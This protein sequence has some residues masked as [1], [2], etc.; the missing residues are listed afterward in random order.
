MD[1]SKFRTRQEFIYDSNVPHRQQFII[2]LDIGYSATKVFYEKGHFV[3]PSAVKKLGRAE[4]PSIP[5]AKD[6]FYRDPSTDEVYI[7][8]YSA[9]EM[10]ES[11]E[12]N[13]TE[14]ELYSRNRYKQFDFRALAG[15]AIAIA[16]QGI[17]A[18]SREV[19]I[20]TGLPSA[21]LQGD[22]NKLID[23]LSSSFSFDYRIGK[24]T[25]WTRCD[26]QI[27]QKNIF[28]MAQPQ[29]SLNS[30]LFTREGGF[31]PKAKDIMTGSV[32]VMDIGF[33]T[34]DFDGYKNRKPVCQE[35]LDSI[36]MHAV[37]TKTS[38]LIQ[39]QYELDIPT[40]ALQKYLKDGQIA[41]IDEE[42]MRSEYKSIAPMLQ[43]A[44]KL[45]LKEAMNRIKTITNNFK[46]FQYLILGGGTGEAWL[47][48]IKDWLK[49]MKTL[50][51][52]SSNIN[53]GLPCI[54][55]NARGY[56]Y[57]RYVAMSRQKKE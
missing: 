39:E 52:I 22:T 54:Y 8:G 40:P 3:I 14:S 1:T 12:T 13:N 33:G 19:I 28:V 57:F 7:I 21:Y 25:N 50:T 55:S 9:Q 41:Y 43:E 17:D 44:N 56:Y 2:G 38:Q 48:D 42:E 16:T 49:N 10:T 5:D 46:D 45:V 53:D 29:G 26:F 47:Q 6:I 18:K 15:V 51:I 27:D 24:T 34:F 23:A 4:M 32:L 30:V 36:G 31:S 20:Q 37:M 11:D 35:S